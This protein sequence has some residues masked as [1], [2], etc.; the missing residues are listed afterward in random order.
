MPC[1]ESS[2]L[3]LGYTRKTAASEGGKNKEGGRQGEPEEAESVGWGP[4]QPDLSYHQPS[5]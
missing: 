4:L 3:L 1:G 5:S 2:N